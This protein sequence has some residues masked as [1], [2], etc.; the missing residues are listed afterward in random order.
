MARVIPVAMAWAELTRAMEQ[1]GAATVA[2][3]GQEA[4]AE[5][6]EKLWVI[7]PF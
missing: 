2:A 1:A 5:R 6:A 3:L 7:P 4:V